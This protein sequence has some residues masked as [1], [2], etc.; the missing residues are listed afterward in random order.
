[1]KTS[2]RP[3]SNYRNG[4]KK[5]FKIG[6]NSSEALS[7][8]ILALSNYEHDLEVVVGMGVNAIV[9]EGEE[10]A[11]SIAPRDTGQLVDSI[12]HET[13]VT[14]NG[15]VV[16]KVIAGTDHA[17]FVEFGVGIEG[18]KNPSEDAIA[19]GWEYDINNHGEEGWNYLNPKDGKFYHTTGNVSNPFMLKTAEH[20]E[21]EAKNIIRKEFQK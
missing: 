1:M 7:E 14:S 18:K 21:K 3:T 6:I 8:L 11:K 19:A 2:G 5:K 16:G 12:T 13:L 10:Y 15:V 17:M 9:R 20:L 4:K